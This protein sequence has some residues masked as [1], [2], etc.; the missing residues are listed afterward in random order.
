MDLATLH[1]IQA[2]FVKDDTVIVKVSISDA[3]A[4]EVTPAP[5]K[6]APAKQEK[7]VYPLLYLCG[8][9]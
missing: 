4:N 1:D 2:G 7:V 3:K 9:M 8:S 5:A 6:P